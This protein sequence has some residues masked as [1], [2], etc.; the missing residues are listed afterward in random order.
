MSTFNAFFI[1]ATEKATLD[2]VHKGFEGMNLRILMVVACACLPVGAWCADPS[3]SPEPRLDTSIVRMAPPISGFQYHSDAMVASVNGLRQLGKEKALAVLKEYH[4]EIGD[5]GDPG[6]R[7]KLHL[8]CR[9]L[10]VNPQ[11]WA[12][13]RLG[14]PSPEINWSQVEQFPLFPLAL[15][16]GVPFLLVNGYSAGGYTTDTPE[17]C[18][19]L[20]EGF[21]LVTA[22]LS[23]TN[24]LDA[25]IDLVQSD[26]FKRL[27]ANTNG[28]TEMSEMVMEQRKATPAP[29]KEKSSS[30]Q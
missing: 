6:E 3:P 19:Q 5:A 7:K 2:A 11:G 23:A 24:H 8:I 14:H 17:K 25:A 22:D 4:R 9:L 16:D 20:C 27:Y 1:R 15:S 30:K 29:K 21:S 26:K 12:T 10:F 28:F 13:P 18:I